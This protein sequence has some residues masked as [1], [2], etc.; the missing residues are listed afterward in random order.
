MLGTLLRKGFI[1]G[2]ILLFSKH[3]VNGA[4]K[5]N[6]AQ[7]IFLLNFYLREFSLLQTQCWFASFKLH[8]I[9]LDNSSQVGLIN[10]TI[11][12]NFISHYP[13]AFCSVL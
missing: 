10:L 13:C 5:Y 9:K 11:F 4:S 8:K 7:N 6:C 12:S 2:F 3:M 1:L